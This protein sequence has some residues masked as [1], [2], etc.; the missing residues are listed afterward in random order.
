MRHKKK[1]R[2]DA[3]TLTIREEKDAIEAAGVAGL[4]AGA[5]A[6]ATEGHI[7]RFHVAEGASTLPALLAE[8]ARAGIEAMGVEVNRPTLDDVFLTLTGRSLRD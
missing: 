1:V 8:L 6:P 3:I 2:G 7:V 5:D 4:L